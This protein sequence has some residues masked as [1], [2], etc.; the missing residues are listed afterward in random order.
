MVSPTSAVMVVGANEKALF[1]PT[2]TSI[3]AANATGANARAKA[4]ID[5]KSMV[6]F[7]CVEWLLPVS[8]MLLP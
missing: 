5:L 3:F 1:G 8:D 7:T 4:M 6:A 2:W